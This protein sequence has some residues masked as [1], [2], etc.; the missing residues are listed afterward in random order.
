MNVTSLRFHVM[1]FLSLNSKVKSS[2][3]EGDQQASMLE[4]CL[5]FLASLMSI[6]TN[7]G[8][9]PLNYIIKTFQTIQYYLLFLGLNE[10]ELDRLEMV[11]LLCMSDRTHSQLME[12]LPEKCGSPQN[13]D[14]DSVLAQV[15]IYLFILYLLCFMMAQFIVNFKSR[16]VFFRWLIT[17]LRISKQVA[18]CNRECMYLKQLSGNSFTTP[19]MF[20]YERCIE[21]IFKHL[22][23]VLRNST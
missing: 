1:E 7:I 8:K 22:W 12:L 17:K 4:S 5:T 13:K 18:R 9:Y 20:F 11:S 21:E 19:F 23:I 15:F 10:S 3:L 6:R 2:F 14:F 16:F